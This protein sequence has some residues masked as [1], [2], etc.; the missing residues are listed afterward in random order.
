MNYMI[1]RKIMMALFISILAINV[2]PVGTYD[3]DFFGMSAK[4]Q[5]QHLLDCVQEEMMIYFYS[6]KKH[7]TRIDTINWL[8]RLDSENYKN[9]K[10]IYD[11]QQSDFYQF[12]FDTE[13]AREFVYD[14]FLKEETKGSLGIESIVFNIRHLGRGRISRKRIVKRVFSPTIKKD[15]VFDVDSDI[16]RVAD[17]LLGIKQGEW[18]IPSTSDLDLVLQ[19]NVRH[20]E[21]CR[22][23]QTRQKAKKQI[24]KKLFI[25][26]NFQK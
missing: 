16:E 17:V 24:T 19:K 22:K 26:S 9:H 6:Y 4:D 11:A 21:A 5:K 20:R 12:S 18:L 3:L 10:K 7:I 15:T 8:N 1:T 13:E 2:E 23:W 25:L 14:L